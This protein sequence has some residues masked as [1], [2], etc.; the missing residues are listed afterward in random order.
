MGGNPTGVSVAS[1][2]GIRIGAEHAEGVE[3]QLIQSLGGCVECRSVSEHGEGGDESQRHG[4]AHRGYDRMGVE[5]PEGF[6]DGP[7]PA[8]LVFTGQKN[9]KLGVPPARQR[10]GR[11]E[12]GGEERTRLPDRVVGDDGSHVGDAVEILDRQQAERH[13]FDLFRPA[14]HQSVEEFAERAPVE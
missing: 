4:L 3:D 2:W 12:S 7:R 10:V 11:A 6:L 8:K 9:D 14:R 1:G 13:R 5:R